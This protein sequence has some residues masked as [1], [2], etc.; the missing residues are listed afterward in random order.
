M[1]LSRFALCVAAALGSGSCT[2]FAQVNGSSVVTADAH[3]GTVSRVTTF[4]QAGA[5]EMANAWCGQYGLVALETRLTF[6]NESM[7]F[8]CVPP[9]GA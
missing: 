6:I 2:F 7:D 9:P 8:A 5:L 1:H 4:T 3:G